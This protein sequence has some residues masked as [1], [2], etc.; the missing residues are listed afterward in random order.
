MPVALE[1]ERHDLALEEIVE[2]LGL[3]A[4]ALGVGV[5]LAAPDGPADLV[6]VVVPTPRP[7]S[8]RARSALSAPLAAAF[9]PLV[10][11]ASSGRRGVFSQTSTPR[12]QRARDAHVVVLEEDDLARAGSGRGSRGRS[13]E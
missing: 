13:S 1:E 4:V 6:A 2:Q 3:D 5:L 9:I 10:P 12:D 11:L 8:R 7:T